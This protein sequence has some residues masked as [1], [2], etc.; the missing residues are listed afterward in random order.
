MKKSTKVFK[1]SDPSQNVYGLRVRTSGIQTENFLANSVCL[2]NHN[3]DK[4]MGNWVDLLITGNDMQ[5]VPVLDDDDPEA[6]LIYGKIERDLLKGASI[7]IIPLAVD[8][9]E[10][11]KCEL[12]EISLTPVPANRNALVIY[13]TKG[14]ALNT[15]E[16]KAYMLSVQTTQTQKSKKNN[17][18]MNEQLRAALILLCAQ[19]GLTIQL[20]AD[21]DDNAI[22]DA[23][24]KVGTKI[25]SLTLSNTQ[26]KTAN[27]QYKAEAD[28]IQLAAN[29][30]MVDKAIEDKLITADTKQQW[31]NLAAASPELAK[32]TLAGLKPVTLSAI[33]GAEAAVKKDEEIK[34][35][36]A[37]TFED[38][39]KNDSLA[40][41]AMQAQDPAKFNT[42]YSAYCLKLKAAGVIA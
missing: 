17:S 28:A 7:G 29:T 34:G 8:G 37:W 3:Y 19:S 30:S 33:P 10:I 26:L 24:Q 38:Y 40:L 20:S 36:E 22:V 41:S 18:K 16:A 31:L 42:L 39:Q 25:T 2:L 9:D 35:R 4:I 11:I 32:S 1:V 23:F 5:A 14:V 12:L 13:N 6:L 21:S 27:D 15:E